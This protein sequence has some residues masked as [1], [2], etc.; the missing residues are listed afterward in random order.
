[1]VLLIHEKE[2]KKLAIKISKRLESSGFKCTLDNVETIKQNSELPPIET[3][4]MIFSQKSN[5]SEK[6]ME[7]YEEIFEN[8]IPLIPYVV[9]DVELSVAMQHFLNS[10]DW[11]NAF[12]ISTDEAIKD[13]SI[14]VNENINGVSEAPTS[15]KKKVVAAKSTNKNQ[16]YAIIGISAVFILILGFFI[17]GNNNNNP[18]SS[19]SSPDELIM[20]SWKMANYQDNMPRQPNEYAD[21]ITNIT[22]L[23][24]N[25]LLKLNEDNS[26]NKYG[27]SQNE[28]GNWQLDP[29]NMV[30]YMWPPGSDDH[31]DMLQIE[32]LSADSL[33]MSIATQVDSVT[34]IITRFTLYKE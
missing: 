26:F 6:I 13:L 28:T 25:F 29:Q 2:D 31:K 7:E 4:I 3:A 12:D 15:K 17:F 21:F 11:I 34:Q 22:A 30:L 9:T 33:I 32:K 16:T 8:E 10:H 24:Q 18:L 1:M 5:L 14:L 19:D 27:F 23:K 20:G